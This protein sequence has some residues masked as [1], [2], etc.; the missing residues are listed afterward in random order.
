MNKPILGII[1]GGQLGSLLSVAA[2]KLGVKTIILSDDPHAPAQHFA[3]VFI[4]G[5]YHDKKNINDFTKLV[6]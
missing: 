4:C 6:D 2:K 5:N 3:D 1:G